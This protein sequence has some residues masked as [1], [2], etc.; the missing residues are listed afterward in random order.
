MVAGVS[1]FVVRYVARKRQDEARLIKKIHEL[2]TQYSRYG[3]RRI[4]AMLGQ[5]GWK[6]N[7][8]KR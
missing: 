5:E 8:K 3:Y 4:T 2:A 6:W 7:L 1:R